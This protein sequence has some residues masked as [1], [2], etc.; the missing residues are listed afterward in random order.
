MIP[1]TKA[2]I[3]RGNDLLMRPYIK[4]NTA[5]KNEVIIINTNFNIVNILIYV[6]AYTIQLYIININTCYNKSQLLI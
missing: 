3:S 5:F 1:L 4:N 2:D 6:S